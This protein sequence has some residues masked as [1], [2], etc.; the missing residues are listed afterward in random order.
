MLLIIMV[1]MY[2]YDIA[3][4]NK[5]TALIDDVRNSDNVSSYDNGGNDYVCGPNDNERVHGKM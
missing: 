5:Y 1:M 3:N 4:D 2:S